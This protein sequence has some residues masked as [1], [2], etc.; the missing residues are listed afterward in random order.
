[1]QQAGA[2]GKAADASN[3]ELDTVAAA[4]AAAAEGGLSDAFTLYLQ[5]LVAVDK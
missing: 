4:L 2:L 3:A 1:M 5:A